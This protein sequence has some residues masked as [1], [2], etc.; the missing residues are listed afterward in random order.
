MI[1]PRFSIQSSPGIWD[2]GV[3]LNLDSWPN[4]VPEGW[5]IKCGEEEIRVQDWYGVPSVFKIPE[6]L[7]A[8]CRTNFTYLLIH[9]LIP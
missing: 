1:I 9:I 2:K 3:G 6:K 7:E 8:V 5:D 4:D